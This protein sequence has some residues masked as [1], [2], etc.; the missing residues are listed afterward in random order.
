[1]INRNKATQPSQ[2]AFIYPVGDT[3]EIINWSELDRLVIAA[4]AHYSRQFRSEIDAANLNST[5]PT[6]ALLGNG[7]TIDYLITQIAL[8]KLHLRVLLLSNKNSPAAR[9][10][11]LKACGAAGIIAD[12]SNAALLAAEGFPQGCLHLLTVSELGSLDTQT[13][14]NTAGFHVDDEWNLQSM[15]IHSSG[16]TGMPK[17][18]IHTNRSL[19][20][21]ARMYRL[22]PDFVIENWYLCFPLFHIAGISIALSGLPNGLPTTFPPVNW[23]PAPSAILSAF[24]S[25]SIL[26]YPADCLHCAPNIIE[27]IHDYIEATTQDFTPL[28]ALKVLQ[29]GGAP[30]SASQLAKLTA[31]GANV[32][33]TYGS[34]EIGPPFRTI[35]HT[36]GN[37]NCY[38]LRNLYSESPLVQM[39]PL[40]DGLFECVVYKGFELAAE[41][42]L[43]EDA[44]NPY[45]T[46]DLFL[47]DP[48]GSGT[49]VLQGRK[50]DILVHDNGEKTHAGAL[51]MS[52]EERDPFIAKAAVFGNGKP[53]TAAVVEISTDGWALGAEVVERRLCDALARCNETTARQSRIDRAMVLILGHG[54]S[55]PVTPKGN[56]R[57]K[58]AWRLY[59][60]R[61]QALYERLLGSDLANTGRHDRNSGSGMTD[62]AFI[63]ACVAE[64]CQKEKSDIQADKTFYDLGLDSQRAIQLRSS[65]IKRFGTFPLMFI[66][67]YPTAEKLHSYLTGL[68]SNHHMVCSE[69]KR[70]AW[71]KE[72]IEKYRSVINIWRASPKHMHE[73][74]ITGGEIVLLTGASGTLGNALLEALVRSPNIKRVYCAIRGQDP[75]KRLQRSLRKRGYAEGIYL[76]SK[77][78]A[79]PYVMTEERLGLTA[80]LY[81]LMLHEVTVVLHNAWKMDFNQRVEMFEPDCLQGTMNILS[82]C[83]TGAKK[84]FCFM[85]SVAAC[86]GQ[87]AEGQTIQESAVDEDPLMALNTGYAQSKFIGALS[88]SSGLFLTELS[89]SN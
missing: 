79:V 74:V 58:E 67:E 60:T 85:S 17:P 21:I 70:L 77:I 9:N 23:P 30:L 48:P 1:M 27:D 6:I 69:E 61:V 56:V 2:A 28:T 8:T 89:G 38:H 50:D 33:T 62:L 19:C 71:I 43:A 40:G 87:A 73:P 11:L 53:C 29:P 22:F 68:R 36:R 88:C 5:Q 76:S 32:K 24:R 35:P 7:N 65:L 39:E 80:E 34:T 55:L 16:S 13:Q 14:E 31:L 25:L 78:Q 57:R 41:L 51:Q 64:I 49:F 12:D 82:F 81:E 4:A 63:E 86:M 3:F 72:T 20:L 26:G 83:S 47:E 15:I 75:R 42:W 54:E 45:R 10:H 18:I 46:N 44:P 37:P 59:G 52:L 84:T 66:F